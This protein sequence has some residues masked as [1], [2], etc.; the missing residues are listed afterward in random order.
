MR[1]TGDQGRRSTLFAFWGALM[2][3]SALVLGS[4][5]IF[6]FGVIAFA[7]LLILWWKGARTLLRDRVYA[8]GGLMLTLCLI[9]FVINVIAELTQAPLVFLSLFGMSFLFPPLITHIY[10]HESVSRLGVRPRWRWVLIFLYVT[11]LSTSAAVFAMVFGLWQID[12][13]AVVDRLMWVMGAS[14]VVSGIFSSY[15][16]SRASAGRKDMAPVARQHKRLKIA[17]LVA[18]ALL[19]SFIFLMGATGRETLTSFLGVISRSLPLFFL[20]FDTYLENRFEFYDVFVKRATFFFFMLTLL[21]GFFTL[22][23]PFLSEAALGEWQ[24]PAAYALTLLPLVLAVPWLNRQMGSWLDRHWLGRR[25]SPSEAVNRLI[26]GLAQSSGSTSRLVQETEQRMREVFQAPVKIVIDGQGAAPDFPVQHEVEIPSSMET[27]V[28]GKILLGPKPNQTPHFSADLTLVGALGQIFS[29]MLQNIRL[30]EQ[31]REQE[32]REQ[33]LIV[34]AGRSEL[35]A[36]RAQINPH[37]LFNALNVIAS[38]THR[39]PDQAEAVVEQLAEV[40][41]YTLSRSEQEWVR[42]EDEVAFIESYLAVEK[43]RFGD[44]LQVQLEIGPEALG[45]LIPTMIIQTLVENAVKHGISQLKTPGRIVIGASIERGELAIRVVDNGP[46]PAAEPGRRGGRPRMGS[47]YGLKNVHSRLEG[48]FGESASL[49][50]RRDTMTGETVAE[51]R[52]PAV[53]AAI[54]LTGGSRQ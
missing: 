17:L 24:L 52:I 36:L 50:L 4:L 49:D 43:A 41:R 28:I 29:Y 14:F 40:F 22:V 11:C 30:L 39:D 6:T 3:A 51:L 48:Y 44:R 15:M 5:S 8:I 46:G 27:G 32:K 19:I 33:S 9:W 21:V 2:I 37:F 25:Y 13:Q 34:E 20:F 54:S 47:S 1:W 42:L 35:K 7:G 23:A 16:V 18:M 45:C 10:Y 38:L 53:T 31:R 26:S 12:M